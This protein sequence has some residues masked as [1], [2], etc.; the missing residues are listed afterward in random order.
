MRG[1]RCRGSARRPAV[2][3]EGRDEDATP[4]DL[5]WIAGDRRGR[6]P[7]RLDGLG[8]GADDRHAGLRSPGQRRLPVRQDAGRGRGRA[9]PGRAGLAAGRPAGP[10]TPKGI[11]TS[12]S[13][14]GMRRLGP[15][16]AAGGRPDPRTSRPP[17]SPP[18]GRSSIPPTE[19]DGPARRPDARPGDRAA[20]PRE[21][22]PPVQVLRDPPG[23]GR[24]PHRQPP[25]QP[26]LLRRRP[27]RPLRPVHPRPAGRPDP[28]RRQHLLP[29]RPLAKRQARTASAIR[30]KQG[31]RG[32]VPGRRPPVDR[33]PLHGLRRRPPGPADG[34]LRRGERRG[35]RRALSTSPR[36]VPTGDQEAEPTSS[37]VR[38]QLKL[39]EQRLLESQEAYRKAKQALATRSTSR[40]TRPRRSRSGARSR[41]R[42]SPRRRSRS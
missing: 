42:A 4:G 14:P 12:I 36:T 22:R 18:P 35:A 10:A 7:G 39:A 1:R 3:K 24:H 34:R 20:D 25:G 17:R 16:R 5:P 6:G 2:T 28:V 41:I 23:P 29:A 15:V 19:E 11:P 8:A 33:Q 40:P 26:G 27:A 31:H 21:P 13:T 30:A 32:A 38:I 37:R 9:S